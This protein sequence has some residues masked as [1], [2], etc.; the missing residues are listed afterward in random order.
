MPPKVNL[1]KES[2]SLPT[3]DTGPGADKSMSF[4]KSMEPNFYEASPGNSIN[5]RDVEIGKA[6]T[7]VFILSNDSGRDVT[8]SAVCDGQVRLTITHKIT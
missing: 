8:F 7:R 2:R 5:F 3:P 4:D 6:S 1:Y